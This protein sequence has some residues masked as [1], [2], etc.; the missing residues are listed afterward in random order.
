[1]TAALKLGQSGQ[2]LKV[3]LLWADRS[4]KS[5]IGFDLPE[6]ERIEASVISISPSAPAPLLDQGDS[7]GVLAGESH[8]Y[9]EKQLK[10][11]LAILRLVRGTMDA[12]IS[13]RNIPDAEGNNRQF[14]TRLQ[15][16][17]DHHD[18]P[19]VKCRIEKILEKHLGVL[20]MVFGK[21]MSIREAVIPLRIQRHR[22]DDDFGEDISVR[23]D[24]EPG[25]HCADEH[26]KKR[27]NTGL[28]C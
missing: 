28:T 20:V 10:V 2:N 26:F 11:G 4:K 19:I 3:H 18:Q 8:F 17:F 1:M 16:V 24:T 7:C 22:L 6:P 23:R 15:T 13:V 21:F 25:P 5:L 27:S 9:C 12:L 14:P